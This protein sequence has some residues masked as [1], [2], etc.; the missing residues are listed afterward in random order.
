MNNNHQ[1]QYHGITKK[2]LKKSYGWKKDIFGIL[3][4]FKKWKKKMGKKT[5]KSQN[6]NFFN[7]KCMRFLVKEGGG[8]CC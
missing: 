1:S 5:Q 7:K 6:H 4:K 3:C 2:S 8:H